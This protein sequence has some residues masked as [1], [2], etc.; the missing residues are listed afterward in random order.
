MSSLSSKLVRGQVQL[1]NLPEQT[2]WVENDVLDIL[3]ANSLGDMASAPT[4]TKPTAV[5][6]AW[7][8]ATRDSKGKYFLEFNVELDFSG[9]D[10]HR[11]FWFAG[12]QS[13]SSTEYNISS[14]MISPTT[15]VIESKKVSSVSRLSMTLDTI[16]SSVTMVVSGTLPLTG[17]PDWF[18]ANR[19]EGFTVLAQ[20]GNATATEPGLL[21]RYQ[22]EQA[23]IPD[24]TAGFSTSDSLH[25]TRIGNVVTLTPNEVWGHSSSATP[26]TAAGLIPVDFRPRTDETATTV[27]YSQTRGVSILVFTDGHITILYRDESGGVNQTSMGNSIWTISYVVDD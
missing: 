22:T 16:Q 1:S 26:S 10:N 24:T 13:S 8:R 20:I 4:S 18:D 5:T 27:D 2:K 23:F 25:C 9:N 15:R 21:P 7:G 11:Q 3:A 17:K 19:E 6:G 14:S 12:V